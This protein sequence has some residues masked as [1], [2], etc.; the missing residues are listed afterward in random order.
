MTSDVGALGVRVDL[1]DLCVKLH[2]DA[3]AE[4]EFLD[5]AVGVAV[6]GDV[7]HEGLHLL[8]GI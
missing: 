4:S 6:F 5:G 3:V 7:L 1:V 2:V 8:F